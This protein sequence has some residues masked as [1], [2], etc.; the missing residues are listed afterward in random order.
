M[1][2]NPIRG[3]TL[4]FEFQDGRMAGKAITHEFHDDGSVDF[5]MA[6]GSKPTHVDKYEV[7]KVSDDAYAVSYLGSSG[8]TLSVVLNFANHHL[9]AFSSNEKMLQLQH[10][11]FAEQ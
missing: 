10:G 5:S 1:S 4:T 6:K 2:K 7:A 9:I 3:K 8:Y 11:T